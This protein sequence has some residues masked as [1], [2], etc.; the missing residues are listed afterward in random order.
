MDLAVVR[1]IED[2]SARAWPPLEQL[3]VDG[4]VLRAGGGVTG[5]ANSVWPRADHGRLTVGE[6]LGAARD[7]Y[8]ARQLPMSVQVTPTAEPRGLDRE[9]GTRGYVVTRAPRSVQVAPLDSMTAMAG[10][11]RVHVDAALS[12]RWYAVVAQVNPSFAG[13]ESA[14]RALLGGVRQPTAYAVVA[15]DGVPAAAGRGVLDGDWLG[16]F[17]MATLPAYRRQGCAA[18]IL[19]ALAAWAAGAGATRAYLQ[20]EADG[21]AAPRLY[22]KAGFEHC[23]E[24]AFWGE[25]K[26]G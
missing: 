11:A 12:D 23:Y 21:E 16:V 1:E 25:P 19:S 2:V 17:N 10:G 26:N 14:A 13:H 22:A 3:D 18:A 8:A 24:Y 9:L 6:K 5:R 7:F 15:V 20:T 4:W